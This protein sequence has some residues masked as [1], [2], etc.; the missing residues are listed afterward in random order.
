MTR[1]SQP[2]IPP[3][4]TPCL[5]STPSIFPARKSPR[6]SG[7]RIG[8]GSSSGRRN[9]I[10]ISDLHGR[11]RVAFSAGSYSILF[12][13]A[14]GVALVRSGLPSR[15]GSCRPRR[16]PPAAGRTRKERL[17]YVA[18]FEIVPARGRG[19]RRNVG[20]RG[21]TGGSRKRQRVLRPE[22]STSSDAA[23]H[24]TSSSSR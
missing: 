23:P 18:R 19:R 13:D 21:R 6:D 12:L 5:K 8:F 24:S 14:P 22:P 7:R 15:I 16:S 10:R 4:C 17:E 3:T 2:S 20:A 11:R 1:S 9:I